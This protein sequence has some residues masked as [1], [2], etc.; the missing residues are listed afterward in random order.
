MLKK[1]PA[2][3]PFIVQ[4]RARMYRG[5]ESACM[6]LP[7]GRDKIRG[8]VKRVTEMNTVDVLDSDGNVMGQTL[9]SPKTPL[10]YRLNGH[11]EDAQMAKILGIDQH[12]RAVKAFMGV[13]VHFL[14]GPKGDKYVILHHDTMSLDI[15]MKMVSEDKSSEIGDVKSKKKEANRMFVS[16]TAVA[17]AQT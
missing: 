7:L 15:G 17:T 12:R 11:T 8:F 1:K 4:E 6:S 13:G 5:L 9:R 3:P 16:E 10:V 2:Q 14:I